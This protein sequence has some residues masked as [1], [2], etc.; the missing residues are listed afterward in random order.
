MKKN[1]EKFQDS[2][3]FN[4]SNII[5]VVLYILYVSLIIYFPKIGLIINTMVLIFIWPLILY[6]NF[7]TLMLKPIP[8]FVTLFNYLFGDLYYLFYIFSI[9]NSIIELYLIYKVFT[10]GNSNET[11]S[12]LTNS[13]DLSD[14][15]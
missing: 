11:D 10:P 1:I 14:L 3:H 4:L 15:E 6:V 2:N 12:K 5:T 8:G 7:L 13:S 9:I